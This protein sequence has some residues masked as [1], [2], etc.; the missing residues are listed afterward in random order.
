MAEQQSSGVPKWVNRM[1]SGILRSPLHGMVSDKI[2]LITFTGRKSGKPYS[3]PVSYTRRSGELLVFTHGKWWRN[4]RGGAPVKVR[5]QGKDLQ[6][7]AEPVDTDTAAIAA[8]LADH[9]RHAPG[10]A[11]FYN[12]TIG[13]NG[14]PNADEIARAA[15]DTVMI[16]IQI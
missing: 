14:V 9:L 11:K 4:L 10:D 1:M 7:C 3:T 16:R 5:V 12:V 13:E 6:G 15:E 2:L 8:G